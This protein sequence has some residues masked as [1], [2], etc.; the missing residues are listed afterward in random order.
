MNHFFLSQKHNWR[1]LDNYSSR[2]MFSVLLLL[3]LLT[4][5]T[6]TTHA[7]Q[8][9]DPRTLNGGSVLAMAGK[10]CV[11][12]A[13]DKRFG[14]GPQVCFGYMMAEGCCFGLEYYFVI[15]YYLLSILG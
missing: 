1:R 13:V 5:F 12:L 15:S 11:A 8:Q 3:L 9:Q 2:S 4:A 6:P 14:S 10:G 7:Q